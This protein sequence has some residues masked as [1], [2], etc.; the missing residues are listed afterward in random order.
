MIHHRWDISPSDAIALQKEL[1]GLVRQ[2]P[3][4]G[5][6][7]TIAGVDCAFTDDNR[8]VAVAVLCDAETME[9]LTSAVEVQP[10]GFPYVSGLL[11]FREAPAVIAAVGKLTPAPDLLMCDGQ[12]VAHPRGLGLASHVGL[13]L[14][15]P[16]I[17]VAKSR[18]RGDH[19]TPGLKRGAK[20]PLR[21]QDHTIG[22]VLRTRDNVKPLYISVGHRVTL[23]E[24]VDW[25]LRAGRGFRLPEPTRLAD[26][27]VARAKRD[28]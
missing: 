9:V 25:V 4:S 17:G 22:A 10:C 26:R 15:V 23:E 24:C 13:W 8:I 18:L 6:V 11:S 1:A 5:D 2:A 27:H 3:L 19:R 14:N 16:T 20:A 28:V 7:R 21:F 12:G